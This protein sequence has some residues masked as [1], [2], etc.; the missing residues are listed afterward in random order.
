MGVLD[1]NICTICT[2]CIE[3]GRVE[4]WGRV[5]GGVATR[6]AESLVEYICYKA[7]LAR[8]SQTAP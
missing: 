1:Q 8:I 5:G 6:R 3:L 7:V 2:E 4:S